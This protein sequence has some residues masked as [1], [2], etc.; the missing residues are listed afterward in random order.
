VG[1]VR[2]SVWVVWLLEVTGLVMP[3][4]EPQGWT[5]KWKVIRLRYSGQFYKSTTLPSQLSFD[6]DFFL[7][8]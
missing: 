2:L 8:S 4:S 5:L 1:E 7:R 3:I 6:L